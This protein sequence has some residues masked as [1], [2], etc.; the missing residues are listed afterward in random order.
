MG[1]KKYYT[2]S[3]SV[4][5]EL[6]LFRSLMCGEKKSNH[7]SASAVAEYELILDIFLTRYH[8]YF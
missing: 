3:R 7:A 1:F 8:I 5:M 4:V 6:R 2:A